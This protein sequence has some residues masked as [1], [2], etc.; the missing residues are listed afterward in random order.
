MRLRERDKRGVVL[1]ERVGDDDVYRWTGAGVE[2]RAAVYPLT[3]ELSVSQYGEETRRMRLLLY[4]GA[5]PRLAEG[6]G[7]CVDVPGG[8]S[9]DYRVAGVDGWAHQRAVLKQIPKDLRR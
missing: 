8:E 3:D 5:E 9:C 2:I 1:R 4:D 7:V 6:M